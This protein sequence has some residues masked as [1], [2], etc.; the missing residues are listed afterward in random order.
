[1]A[2]RCPLLDLAN[3]PRSWSPTVI[4]L[5]DLVWITPFEVAGLAAIWTRLDTTERRPR[6]ELPREAE[7]KAYL[8]DIG[9]DR[10]IPGPWGAGGGSRIEP[11]WLPL[12][13]ISASEEWDDLLTVL[14]PALADLLREP[15]LTQLTMDM[16][17]ELVDNAATHGHSGTGT[18]VCAQLYT[19]ATSG[20]SPGIWI[21]IADG[22]I[23][24]PDHLRRNP[25]YRDISDDRDL[26]RLARQPWVT[27]TT[28]R[29]GWGLVQVFED[30]TEAGPTRLVIR[31]GRAQGEFTLRLGQRLTARY[32]RVNPLVPGTWIHIR[33]ETA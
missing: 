25:K 14:H 33:V 9:L 8:V 7:V 18:F 29:R 24:V 22:G 10:L 1:M 2:G 26:I 15:R 12:T 5:T 17:S 32:R 11:P 23:G 21:G 6:V 30:A 31:S 27:G 20:L 19:G 13:R 16:M 4:D 3:M 28:D